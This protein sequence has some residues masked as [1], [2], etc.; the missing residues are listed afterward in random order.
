MYRTIEDLERIRAYAD[1][2]RVGVVIGG[3]LLGPRSS[4]RAQGDGT[5]NPRGRALAPRLMAVQ[6]DDAGG[7]VLRSRIEELGLTVHTGKTTLGVDLENGAVRALKFADGSELACDMVV[8]SAGIRPRD[9]LARA[10]G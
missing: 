8:F 10:S 7:L 6:I 1:R 5:R 3:G 4:K 9:E 2:S